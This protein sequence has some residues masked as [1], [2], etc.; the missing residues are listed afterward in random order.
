M[1]KSSETLA[2]RREELIATINAQRELMAQCTQGMT[3]NLS[4]FESGMNFVRKIKL[5]P[6]VAAVAVGGLLVVIKP[7]H[8]FSILQAGLGVWQTV[9]AV[10]PGLQNLFGNNRNR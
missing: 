8:I 6:I 10:S 7:R 1:K 5:H 2:R 4:V 9:R 3:S